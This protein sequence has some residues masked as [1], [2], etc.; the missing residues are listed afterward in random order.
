MTPAALQSL[1]TAA[2]RAGGADAASLAVRAGGETVTVAFGAATQA[3]PF[4]MGSIA[5]SFT[6]ALVHLAVRAGRLDLDRPV[7][8]WLPDLRLADQTAAARLTA[9]HLLTHQ[10]GF[11]G[12]IFDD[13][14]CAPDAV[15]RHVAR[16]AM[17]EQTVPPGTLTSYCNAGIVLAARLA[18]VA[19]GHDW[20]TLFREVLA[21][22]LGLQSTMARREAT[23]P[24]VM[25]TAGD[26][27]PAGSPALRALGP[28]GATPYASAADL[29]AWAEA[30]WEPPP[31]GLGLFQVMSAPEVPSPSPSFA[32]GFG[33]GLMRFSADAALWGHDGAVPGQ[34]SFL[35]MAPGRKVGVALMLAGGD[36]R[37]IAHSVLSPLLLALADCTVP[38]PP[39]PAGPG[40]A[41]PERR[42]EIARI[43][44]DWQA[45]RY[46]IQVSPMD[47]GACLCFRP[48]ADAGDQTESY[49]VILH[50]LGQGAF[51]TLL[52][53]S[54][55]PTIQQL[56]T[57]AE[58][59]EFLAFR[60]RLFRRAG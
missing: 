18:E 16:L 34:A 2:C 48:A 38:A 28:A 42:A 56:H 52:P 54:A 51:A 3:L 44:G 60:G 27:I 9:R 6:A 58:G 36:A 49:E 10:G 8:H 19:F 46:H 25:I 30:L 11:F 13:E 57:D 22:P 4:R 45:P 1:L 50:P 39:D 29:V 17:A 14:G 5:K 40:L 24:E 7:A 23:G 33:P 32:L 21:G 41:G 35:R 59:A 47:G 31:A 12:D 37:L 15:A 43:S 26:K 20:E 55:I 53:G